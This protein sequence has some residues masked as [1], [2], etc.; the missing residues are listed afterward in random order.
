[1]RPKK[2][3]DSFVFAYM[4]L[5]FRRCGQESNM[6]TLASAFMLLIFRQ[7]DQK[8]NMN[9]L[10]LLICCFSSVDATKKAT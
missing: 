8:S 1:M 7:C 9:P 10:S 5:F 4:L 3:H 2:Q 6:E